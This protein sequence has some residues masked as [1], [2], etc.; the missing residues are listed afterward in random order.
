MLHQLADEPAVERAHTAAELCTVEEAHFAAEHRAECCADWQA[1]DTPLVVPNVTPEQLADQAAFYGS[2][3]EPYE[4]ADDATHLIPDVA[5]E[6]AAV[7]VADSRANE[8]ADE[9]PN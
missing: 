1:I 3:H 6:Q 8:C 4:Q 2:E 9:P 7:S 5:P